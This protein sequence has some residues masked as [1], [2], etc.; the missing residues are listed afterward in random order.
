MAATLFLSEDELDGISPEERYN[1]NISQCR[2]YTNVQQYRT[3]GKD[4]MTRDVLSIHI[5]KYIEAF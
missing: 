2:C 3:I 1:D 5:K 4:L